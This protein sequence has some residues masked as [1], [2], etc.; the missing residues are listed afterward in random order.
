MERLMAATVTPMSVGMGVVTA[1]AA[2]FFMSMTVIVPTAAAALLMPMAVI[3]PAT[4]AVLRPVGVAV[5]VIGLTAAASAASGSTGSSLCGLSQL[6]IHLHDKFNALKANLLSNDVHKVRRAGVRLGGANQ[7]Q[8]ERLIA[9]FR[10]MLV[11]LAIQRK[12]EVSVN[13]LLKL[14]ELEVPP[15]PRTRLGHAKD[16]GSGGS[17]LRD[18]VDNVS[19][20][21]WHEIYNLKKTDHP[22]K[23]GERP[24]PDLRER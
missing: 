14:E 1:T 12:G 20:L 11:H 3:V 10:E 9:K 13:L 5:I 17:V 23:S 6:G 2:A 19:I 4:A 18:Q 16:D 7:L 24:P 8:A 15:V 21:K 22:F